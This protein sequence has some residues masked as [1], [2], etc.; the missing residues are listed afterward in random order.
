MVIQAKIQ[1][2][3]DLVLTRI[4]W[5]IGFDIDV[6]FITNSKKRINDLGNKEYLS[7][8]PT[9]DIYCKGDTFDA[10]DEACEREAKE[11]L[12]DYLAG[13]ISWFGNKRS[14]ENG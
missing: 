10:A 3:F 1:N 6:V 9:M 4:L 14:N 8:I 5:N 13:D 2:R 11:F 12:K 7:Y